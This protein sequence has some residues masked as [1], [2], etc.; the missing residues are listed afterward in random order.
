M[1]RLLIIDDEPI[2]VNGMNEYFSKL[3]WHTPPQKRS[4][5]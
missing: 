2:I 1:Y 5:G 3:F 4:P